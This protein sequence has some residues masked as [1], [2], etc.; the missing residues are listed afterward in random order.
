VAILVIDVGTTH[1]KAGLF[2][3]GGAALGIAT[4]PTPHDRDRSGGAIILPERLWDAVAAAVAAV[5]AE[6]P[7]VAA[8]GVAGMAETGLLLGRRDGRPRTPLLPWFDD[9]A[10]PYA[11]RLAGAAAPAE[12]FATLGIY[13]SFKVSL[14]KILQAGDGAPE[15]LDGAVWLGA[16]EYIAYRLSGAHGTDHSLAGRTYA[17]DLRARAWDTAWLRQLGLPADLFAPAGPSGAPLGRTGAGLAGLGLAPGTPVAVC[18]HDHVC[19]A[20]ATGAVEPGRALDSMGT[21]EA[22]IGALGAPPEPGAA[23][24]SGLT[25]GL[26]P[27]VERWYWLGGLSAAGGS[28]D[29]LRGILGDPPLSYAQLQALQESLGPEPGELLFLPY[30][31]G[32]GAPRPSPAARGAF[33]GLAAAHTRADMLRAVLEGAA[34]QLESIRRAAAGL[35]GQPPATIAVAGGGARNRRWLQI[36][37]DIYGAPLDVLA[38]DEATLLGAALVVGAGCGVYRDAAEALA[39]AARRPAARVEPDAG[40]HQIYAARFARDF[41]PW[42]RQLT[43]LT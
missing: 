17:F 26:L 14:A 37:A 32:S 2:G 9:S 30:L 5:L 35:T 25:F 21:A 18:G 42:Q 16:P 13:P 43:Q 4:R 12:R 22:L 20:V 8:V 10:A 28:L 31:A 27:L 29:W 40:R 38:D 7:A 39:V 15:L 24:A 23:L 19:A 3:E 33:I 36:K 11:A 34:Y 1:C 6:R 41:A